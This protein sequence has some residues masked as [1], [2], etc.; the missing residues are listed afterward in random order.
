[1]FKIIFLEVAVVIVSGWVMAAEPSPVNPQAGQK[2]SKSKAV[3]EL[4]ASDEW[5]NMQSASNQYDAHYI[6]ATNKIAAV[7]DNATKTALTKS[8][9]A[10]DDCHD[11]LVKLIKCFK[12]Y[13]AA[14]GD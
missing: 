1:M 8:I 10:T 14:N 13:V 5:K 7:S 2:A 11:A 4:K 6:D 3:K 9:K 12:D